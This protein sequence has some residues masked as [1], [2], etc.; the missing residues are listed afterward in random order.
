MGAGAKLHFGPFTLDPANRRLLRNGVP[1]ELNGRYL[2][3]LALLAREPGG[4]ITKD[5]F[6]EEVW[7]GVPVTD[8]A[9]TQ[10]IRTLRRILEDDAAR[11]RYIETVPRHGYRFI[12]PITPSEAQGQPPPPTHPFPS[13]AQHVQARTE[14][15][16]AGLVGGSAAG[17]LGGLAY[18]SLIGAGPGEMGGASVLGVIAA[19][20]LLVAVLGGG[21]VS[22]GVALTA[23]PR[24]SAWSVLG[25]ALGGL[26][27]GGVV[28]LLG[29][30]AL[31]LLF[32]RAPD[33]A[34]GAPEGALL[35]AGI[36]LAAWRALRG[37]GRPSL[38]AAAM[39]GGLAGG[40]AGLLITLAGGR[41]LAGSL[42]LLARHPD[43]RLSLDRLADL[44][45]AERFG[46]VSLAATATLE[47]A[48][49][50]AGVVAAM[51]WAIQRRERPTPSS[52]A[53]AP[54]RSPAP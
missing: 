16:L 41:L 11:P 20:T 39:T 12:A 48:L 46:P 47:G 3:A 45:G 27:I 31:A 25:G 10:C 26:L 1:V 2:D 52:P 30:D 42:E 23:S 35:G 43:S 28:K 22:L 29:L 19:L 49:F 9:L 50:G 4:L 14:L 32:G 33:A 34:T 36:G 44:F 21:A 51:A 40:A 24:P 54:L 17:L 38:R 15:A 18:G 13:P 6:L 7:R 8:E 37:D 53:A 5:R